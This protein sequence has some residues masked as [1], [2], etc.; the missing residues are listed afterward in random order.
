MWLASKSGVG[1][2]LPFKLRPGEFSI[3][4]SNE[5]QIVLLD[6]SVSRIHARLTMSPSGDLHLI[7]LGS[8]NGTF[9]NDAP[10]TEA[11]PR[12]NDG[13]RLG[14]VR[15]VLTMDPDP[16]QHGALEQTT[17]LEVLSSG[18]TQ[19]PSDPPLSRPQR[20]VLQLV[21]KGLND[22]AIAR[23]LGRSY[24]TIRNHLKLVFKAFGVHSKPELLGK[25]H[26]KP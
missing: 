14:A 11:R 12:I 1:G 16:A 21:A 4:R 23:L 20:E 18:K 24:Y 19:T 5:C 26:E 2:K 8:R 17:R 13:L 7:D 9:V 6:S 10:V 25:L 15:L 3:G 22:N